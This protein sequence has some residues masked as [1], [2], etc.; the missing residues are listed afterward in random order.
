MKED[1]LIICRCEEITLGEIKEAVKLGMTTMNEIKRFTRAG[2]GLCQGKTCR[3]LVANIVC[4]ETK[5]PPSALV[6]ST[7]RPP[8][9]PVSLGILSKRLSDDDPKERLP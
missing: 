6:P 4:C 2:M 1:D 7:Y 5:Q 3:H 9:R 8:I